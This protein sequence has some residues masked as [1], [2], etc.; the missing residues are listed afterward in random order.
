ML[1][2]LIT[3]NVVNSTSCGNNTCL[4][5]IRTNE[6]LLADNP[7]TNTAIWELRE[8]GVNLTS[9]GPNT[10]TEVAVD[11]TPDNSFNFGG[12]PC[13]R[14]H[15]QPNGQPPCNATDADALA[16]W[17]NPNQLTLDTSK[18]IHP[19]VPQ[20]FNSDGNSLYFQGGSSLNGF[21]PGNSMAGTYW[22]NCASIMIDGPT[23][24]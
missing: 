16:D 19:Q 6:L 18:G 8:F 5:H 17:I 10:I 21:Q 24:T 14:L 12:G 4:F 23:C 1:Q 22:N 13:L 9:G 2:E 11:Q 7:G 15:Q 20:T 3:N